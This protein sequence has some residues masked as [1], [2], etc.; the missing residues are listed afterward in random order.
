M[1]FPVTRRLTA[2]AVPLSLLLLT[3]CSD[4]AASDSPNTD[5]AVVDTVAADENQAGSDSGRLAHL[6]DCSRVE[7]AVSP[8]ID[9]LVPDEQNTVD[10]WGVSCRWDMAE[11]ETNW[12]N[13]RSVS[14]GI[15]PEPNEKPD[16]AQLAEFAEG[17]AQIEDSWVAEQGGV[18][19]TMGTTTS[20][21]AAIVTT[22]WLPYAEVTIA[23]GKWGDYP[24]LDGAAAVQI[25]QQLLG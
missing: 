4:S 6:T 24:A 10:E 15:S 12:E 19:Y 22:V 3:S 25:A 17:I 14:V 7:T 9:G 1:L 23:G 16:V 18:A 20:V 11:N 8:F 2:I 5:S 13:N 21:A